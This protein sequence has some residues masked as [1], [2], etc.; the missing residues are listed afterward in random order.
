MRSPASLTEI[1]P[2]F[3]CIECGA[4][5]VACWNKDRRDPP[6]LGCVNRKVCGWTYSVHHNVCMD[7]RQLNYKTVGVD[8]EKMTKAFKQLAWISRYDVQG[9]RVE[10]LTK[11]LSV[12]AAARVPLPKE[13]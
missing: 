11:M 5:M 4:D 8:L 6:F 2:W 1:W 3:G 7:L 13:A 12:V 9:R 10:F